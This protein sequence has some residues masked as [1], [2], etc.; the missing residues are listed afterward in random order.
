MT[1]T[2]VRPSLAWTILSLYTNTVKH[3]SSENARIFDHQVATSRVERTY[4]TRTAKPFSALYQGYRS[5]A[6][7][8]PVSRL[9]ESCG[10]K[11][12]QDFHTAAPPEIR[13]GYRDMR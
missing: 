8:L 12:G 11:I 2:T 1:L 7:P 10:S 6:L 3:E 4:R 13:V 9:Q 5:Y